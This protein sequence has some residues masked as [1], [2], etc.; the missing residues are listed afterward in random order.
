MVR[1]DFVLSPGAKANGWGDSDDDSDICDRG[2]NL[3]EE[4]SPE[5][6]YEDYPGMNRSESVMIME[7][8]P[9]TSTNKTMV[10]NKCFFDTPKRQEE[11]DEDKDLKT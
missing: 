2:T 9:V 5:M 1:P 10:R 4:K 8:M 7:G 11:R 6:D 3:E